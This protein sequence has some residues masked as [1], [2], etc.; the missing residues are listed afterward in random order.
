ML[1]IAKILITHYDISY[2]KKFI[3]PCT[4]ENTTMPRI[5]LQEYTDIHTKQ[6]TAI[7]ACTARLLILGFVCK[8][9]TE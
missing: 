7:Q 1:S 3:T 4:V 6:K 2:G 5:F 9:S 8:M